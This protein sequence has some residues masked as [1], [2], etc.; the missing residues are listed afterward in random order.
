MADQ[1]RT[2]SELS[3]LDYNYFWA[4]KIPVEETN[5]DVIIKK[6]NTLCN[7]KANSSKPIELRLFKDLKKDA[8][9]VMGDS[10]KRAAEA[11]SYKR[12]KL[13]PV[14]QFVVSL[15]NRGVIYK[16]ELQQ[17]A[18]KNK[19]D[20]ADLEKEIKPLLGKVKYIDDMQNLFDFDTY[21]NASQLL[22]AD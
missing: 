17:V 14:R 8:L 11:A 22:R 13:E 10:T 7:T 12:L 2:P 1:T 15:C 21:E 18:A 4:Y 9:D 6:I 3:K 19:V 5:A 20:I 16:S